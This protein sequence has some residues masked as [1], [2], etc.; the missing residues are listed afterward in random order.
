MTVSVEKKS[1][2]N[3]LSTIL[4]NIN[5]EQG[6]VLPEL[7]KVLGVKAVTL[8]GLVINH[9]LSFVGLMNE[10]AQSLRKL[11]VI[12]MQ[13]RAPNFLPKATIREL[14]RL[15][16]TPEAKAVYNQLWDVAEAVQAGNLI[17]AQRDVDVSLDDAIGHLEFALTALKAERAAHLETKRNTR[18]GTD[19]VKELD[20]HL[21]AAAKRLTPQGKFMDV[22]RTRSTLQRKLKENFGLDTGRYS[23]KDITKAKLPEAKAFLETCNLS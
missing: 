11:G 6:M 17:Q 13:G 2:S 10:T 22:C 5:G 23:Y 21:L 14:V 18:L 8:R 4:V 7:A 20:R 3:G 19:E 12:S 9:K 15:V 16:G 1:L